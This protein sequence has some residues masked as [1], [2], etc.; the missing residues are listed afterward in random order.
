MLHESERH[1]MSTPS[2]TSQVV[3]RSDAQ[4]HWVEWSKNGEANSLGPYKDFDTAEQV[5]AAKERELEENAG[6]IDDASPYRS[7]P[8]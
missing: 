6:S 7:G 2:A 4:G 3:L 1:S 5:K 8:I